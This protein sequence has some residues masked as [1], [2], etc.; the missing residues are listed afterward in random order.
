MNLAI[1]LLITGISVAVAAL[2]IPGIEIVGSSAWVAVAIT[3]LVLALLNAYLKPLLQVLS[4]GAVILTFGLFSLVINA[5]VLLIASSITSGWL[6]IGFSVAG[7]WPAF[8]GGIIISI[9]SS[10]LEVFVAND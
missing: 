1:R 3:A 6:G 4:C 10:L 9:V 5:I 7:F 8:W 2:I